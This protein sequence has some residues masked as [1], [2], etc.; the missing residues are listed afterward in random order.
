VIYL[1]EY[2]HGGEKMADVKELLEPLPRMLF[3]MKEVAAILGVNENTVIELRKAGLLK[4]MKLGR[5][6]IRKET[7]QQFLIDYE[8]KDIS[9]FLINT[10]KGGNENV[11]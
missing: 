10:N 9:E 2:H 1:I 3:T 8:G 4:F 11:G 6:K 5:Y 7:L